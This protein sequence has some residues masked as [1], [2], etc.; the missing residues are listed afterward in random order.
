MYTDMYMYLKLSQNSSRQE[1]VR[2]E[3]SLFSEI[4]ATQNPRLN[5]TTEFQY[6]GIGLFN[7][8]MLLGWYQ[9]HV[10]TEDVLS[11][12]IVE[13]NIISYVCERG[14]LRVE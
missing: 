13:Y 10:N 9:Q 4:F 14:L 3:K 8:R 12:H 5:P 6:H 7:Q 11:Q 2:P 1:P